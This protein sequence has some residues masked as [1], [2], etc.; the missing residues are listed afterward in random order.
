[1]KTQLQFSFKKDLKNTDYNHVTE[2][3]VRDGFELYYY[4]NI[5]YNDSNKFMVAWW[6]IDSYFNIEQIQIGDI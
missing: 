3:D 4:E 6:V 1:M 5:I 2:D